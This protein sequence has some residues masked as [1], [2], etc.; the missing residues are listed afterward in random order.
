VLPD[1]PFE[2]EISRLLGKP[3]VLTVD[4]ALA[5]LGITGTTEGTSR[6]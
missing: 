4:D 5:A 6:D 2:P 1:T 3:G